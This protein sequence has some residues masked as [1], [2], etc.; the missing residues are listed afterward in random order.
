MSNDIIRDAEE[1]FDPNLKQLFE[2]EETFESFRPDG[3]FNDMDM[4]HVAES[5]PP[6]EERLAEPEKSNRV[7]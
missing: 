4:T 6:T 5:A 7:L 1:F 2:D 3:S